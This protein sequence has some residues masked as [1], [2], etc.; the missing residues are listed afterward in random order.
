MRISVITFLIL[1]FFSAELSAQVADR[2]VNG[3]V[4]FVTANSVY[5]RFDSTDDIPIG[6]TLKLAGSDCLLVTDKSSTSIVCTVINNCAVEK[7]DVVTYTI[8]TKVKQEEPI[9]TDPNTVIPVERTEPDITLSQEESLYTE[10][11]RGRVSLA[12]YNT[13]SD[14]RN[15]R[16]RFRTRFSL[17]ADHIGD[18][19]F[20]IESFLTYRNVSSYDSEDENART[21]IFNIYNLNVRY[22]ATPT[23]SIAAGRRINPKTTTVGAIDGLQV[24]KYFGDFYVGA[25]GGFRPD[26]ENY[27]FNSDLLQY[28][29]YIGIETDDEDFWSQTTVGA[30]EQTNAGATDRRFIY[31]QH[32]STIA[33]DLSL[34][35]SMELDIF[36]N[37]GSET[38]LT[39]LYMSARYR[40]SRA[41]NIMVSY[42]SR[43]QI[44]Y[45]ETFQTEIERLLD[46]DLARQGL[47]FRL[48]VRPAKILWAGISYS[49]RSQSNNENKSDNINAYITLTKIPGIGGRFNVSYNRNASNYLTSNIV[50]GR[51]SR[52]VVKNKVNADIYYRFAQYT[53]ERNYQDFDQHFYGASLF[54]RITRSWQFS[55]SGELSQYEE[56]SSYRFYTQLSKRF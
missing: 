48:N 33:S 25:L 12:S 30:M 55:I 9:E 32:F 53:Y 23:L 54:W 36:G 45:Y 8:P 43:K 42:D 6:K 13:F 26:F 38:R 47:R 37:A 56:E 34:F 40:F 3:T 41:A 10:K 22:D 28:G 44:I 14:V 51:Y 39:N 15:D 4:S 17:N 5:V 16:H 31:L 19:K 20:S 49:M 7:G 50:S 24:E 29:G 52:E 18:S 46:E 2:T 21:D 1:L 35:S 27:G 11:I